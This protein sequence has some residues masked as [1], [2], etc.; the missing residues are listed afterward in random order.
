MI[1]ELDVAAKNTELAVS[2]ELYPVKNEQKSLLEGRPIVEDVEYIRIRIPGQRDEIHRALRESDKKRFPLQYAAWKANA[3][4]G[5]QVGT[6]LSDAPF[7][8][9]AQVIEL[10]FFGCK[11][12]EQLAGMSDAAAQNV[13]P[14]R[15]LRAK[16]QAWLKAAQ[17]NAP[18]EQMHAAL[19]QKDEE[20]QALK[21][22]VDQLVAAQKAEKAEKKQKQA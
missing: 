22:T 21:A 6:L 1:P 8:S 9:K 4:T 20:L 3:Q 5:G 11:T 19:K 2:F 16:A 14:I 10:E 18:L 17:G 13:G 15:E 7:V 12:V